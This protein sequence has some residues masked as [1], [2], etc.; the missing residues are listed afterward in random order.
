[1]S[2]LFIFYD[3][4]M[5]ISSDSKLSVRVILVDGRKLV[6]DDYNMPSMQA[7]LK[8]TLTK[9]GQ[10]SSIYYSKISSCSV[11][12][13]LMTHQMVD[14]SPSKSKRNNIDID[15]EKLIIQNSC[16]RRGKNNNAK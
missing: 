5:P 12:H 2:T 14:T 4:V 6:L 15:R 7:H 3:T 8:V 16:Y 9:E 13:E 1:M 11:L 10:H